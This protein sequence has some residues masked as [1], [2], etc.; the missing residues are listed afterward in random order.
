MQAVVN[1][2]VLSVVGVTALLGSALLVA[3][4]RHPTR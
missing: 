4:W 2:L 1:A 3:L